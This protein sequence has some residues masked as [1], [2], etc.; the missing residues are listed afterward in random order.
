MIANLQSLMYR[1]AIHPHAAKATDLTRHHSA[2]PDRQGDASLI[3]SDFVA[4]KV[5]CGRGTGGSGCCGGC[6]NQ[7]SSVLQRLTL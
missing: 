3:R 6:C 2:L 4:G 1:S 7:A 5:Q